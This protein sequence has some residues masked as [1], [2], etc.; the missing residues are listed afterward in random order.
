MERQLCAT[1]GFVRFAMSILCAAML[2]SCDI[3]ADFG[4]SLEV[5]TLEA[6]EYREEIASIDRL[7]FTETGLGEE[8]IRSLARLL[9]GLAARIRDAGSS[10]FLDVESRELR[11]L[12]K[13]AG[14]LS[15]GGTAAA[16]RNDWMRIRNNLFDDRAWFARS[17]ADLDA[18]APISAPPERTPS[19]REETAEPESRGAIERDSPRRALSGR[20]KVAA[21]F[22]N[23]E[24]ASDAELAGSVWSFDQPSLV[25]RTGEDRQTRFNFRPEGEFLLVMTPTGEDGWIRWEIDPEGL[26]IAFFD[27]MG[28]RPAG[29]EAEPGRRDPAHVML[30][31]V[32][33][34]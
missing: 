13:R 15:P 11:L 29:F 6:E 5:E 27:G 25:I 17:A 26:R 7:V 14:R 21:T 4:D 3:E 12:A 1:I 18:A 24:P 20:W 28:E 10:K 9:D 30:R 32:P 34:R 22:I 8:G 2:A 16:L 31:L 33:V 23:G 19:P